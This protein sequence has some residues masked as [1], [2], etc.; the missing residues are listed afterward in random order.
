MYAYIAAEKK[1]SSTTPSLNFTVFDLRDILLW[2]NA[3]NGRL[4]IGCAVAAFFFYSLCTDP[5]VPLDVCTCCEMRHNMT[6]GGNHG[7]ERIKDEKLRKQNDLRA[8]DRG[9]KKKRRP[10]QRKN[11]GRGIRSKIRFLYDLYNV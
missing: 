8:V 2:S 5:L 1:I 6:E 4:A 7:K 11:N 3:V 9:K 10:D